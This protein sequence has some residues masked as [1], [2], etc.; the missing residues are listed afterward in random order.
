MVQKY[1]SVEF[2]Q[3]R[4][5]K[6]HLLVT[7]AHDDGKQFRAEMREHRGE[8]IFDVSQDH[9]ISKTEQHQHVM[10]A[11]KAVLEVLPE[12]IEIVRDA[13]A[14]A[15]KSFADTIAEEAKVAEKGG[16]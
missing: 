12:L 9:G 5:G 3:Q 11:G 2:R 10:E 4:S 15:E 16:S 6:L 8:V 1:L 7:I 14:R 13:T